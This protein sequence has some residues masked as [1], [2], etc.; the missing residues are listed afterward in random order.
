[1]GSLPS[2]PLSL[3]YQKSQKKGNP[4]SETSPPLKHP[5]IALRR[6]FSIP[7]LT[8]MAAKFISQKSYPKPTAAA[9]RER[10]SALE[11]EWL[12]ARMPFWKPN[13]PFEIGD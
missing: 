6:Q 1:M 12:P 2:P 13:F 8:E 10:E 9:K 4:I 7:H 11:G 3:Y 5:G